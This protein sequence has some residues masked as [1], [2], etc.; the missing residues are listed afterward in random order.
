MVPS[1]FVIA[2]EVGQLDE[3][4]Y[5]HWVHRASSGGTTTAGQCGGTLKM[6]TSGRSSSLRSIIVSCTCGVPEV[7]MEGS[8][9]KSALKDLGL[10]CR[11]TRP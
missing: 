8:F 9:R 4:P 3:F 2:C 5:W 10:R 1:R 11:G 6:R 7:S